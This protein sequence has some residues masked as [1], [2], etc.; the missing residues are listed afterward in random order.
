MLGYQVNGGFSIQLDSPIG[1]ILNRILSVDIRKIKEDKEWDHFSSSFERNK[2]SCI[3][4]NL[5][6]R[7]KLKRVF[8]NNSQDHM[9]KHGLITHKDKIIFK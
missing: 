1:L 4:D 2:D 7:P 3:Y 8:R 6:L 5:I 9:L